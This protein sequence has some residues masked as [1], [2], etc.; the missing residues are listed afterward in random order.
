MRPTGDARVLV[1]PAS[2]RAPDL[3]RESAAPYHPTSSASITFP[4]GYHVH[5]QVNRMASEPSPLCPLFFFEHAPWHHPFAKESVLITGPGSDLRSATS[6]CQSESLMGSEVLLG[7]TQMVNHSP[8]SHIHS[9]LWT[10]SQ[11]PNSNSCKHKKESGR[12]QRTRR[13][14]QNKAL[15]KERP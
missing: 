4:S 11:G 2:L 8:M 15:N 7:A 5:N 13:Q 12:P 14:K 6:R 3:P 9:P 10:A 1:E